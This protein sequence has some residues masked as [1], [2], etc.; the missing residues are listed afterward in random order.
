M[1]EATSPAA[2]IGI[3]LCGLCT[4]SEGI[5]LQAAGVAAA[6]IG[7][8]FHPVPSLMGTF[9]SASTSG[10]FLG[11]LIAGRI[12]DR[13]GRRS[14]LICSVLVF[15]GCSLLNA[16]AWNIPSLICFRLLTGLGLGGAL[17]MVMAYVSETSTPKRQRANVAAVYAMMP[18]GG[19]MISVVSLLVASSG[20]RAFFLVGGVAPLLAAPL[21]VRYLPESAAFRHSKGEGGI[22]PRFS[23][24]LADGRAVATALLWVS[25]LLELLLLYLLLNWLP[26]LLLGHG[27]TRPQAALAQIGFNLGGVVTSLAIGFSLEG[28][29]RAISIVTTFVAVPL[30]VVLLARSNVE[31]AGLFPIVLLLGCAVLAAQAY[32]YASA[33]G[34]YP[35]S[36]RGMGTGSA[37]AAGR[38]GSI[39]GPQLGGFLK[40]AGHDTPHL[41]MDILPLVI[42][43]SVAS[44]AFAWIT[45]RRP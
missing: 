42:A 40:S 17:P 26:T 32:L 7:G 45:R 38:V 19:A 34:L 11:A 9:F 4:F 3:I 18:L 5:D 16:M 30:L 44:L 27:A 8:E 25:F 2:K 36:I 12:A 20:W 1:A 24:V 22:P 37:V 39:V 29:L 21:L 41:L 28:R 13:I 15:G 33:P 31:S 6:G 43:G 14:V 23:A 35:V 10:L